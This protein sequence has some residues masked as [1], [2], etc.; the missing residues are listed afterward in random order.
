VHAGG[1]DE[2]FQGG[3]PV[4]VGVDLDSTYCY[5]LAAEDQRDGETGAIQLWDLSAQGWQPDYTVA[6]G[7]KGL[8]T[9]QAR[10]WPKVPGHGDVF[11][12]LQAMNRLSQ[13]LDNRA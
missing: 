8:R 5:L 10:A 13:R 3:Q 4:R 9:G 7:G 12:A 11:H 6:D 1:H 2:I